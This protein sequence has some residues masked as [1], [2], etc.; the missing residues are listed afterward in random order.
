[1]NENISLQTIKDYLKGK[2][3][4]P[5][6]ARV[7][8]YL[9]THME[10]PEVQKLLD[11]WFDDCRQENDAIGR[12]ALQATRERLGLSH[13]STR[14]FRFTGWLVAAAVALLL[15]LPFAFRIGYNA[16]PESAPVAWNEL[17]VPIAETREVTLPDGTVLTL[18]AGSRV[19][20]PSEFKADKREVFL[21]GEVLAHV[22]KNP[23]KPFIIHSGEVNVCVY[24]TTFNFKSYRDASVVEVMLREGSVGLEVPAGEGRREVRLTPGDVVQYNREGGDVTLSRVSPDDFKTFADGRSFSFINIPL[25]D[26]AANLERSFGTRIVIADERIA[27]QRFL[28]F[29]TNGE[30]LDDILKL[31]SRNGNLRVSRS[32]SMVYLRRK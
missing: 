17:T 4:G 5:E 11:G 31:L 20:W 29:F 18:N 26:I 19:T 21:D 15:A 1:M 28:A 3:T 22:T 23:E 27:D 25:K 30:S 2:L 32:G 6:Q 14:T 24:G 12:E 7:Q 10:D 9:S 13:K 16:R 8:E